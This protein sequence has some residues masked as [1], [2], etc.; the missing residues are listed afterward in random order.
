MKTCKNA[1]ER[2]RERERSAYEQCGLQ[3]FMLNPEN[4]TVHR[5]LDLWWLSSTLAGSWVS[6]CGMLRWLRSS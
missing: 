4:G 5:L 2:E 1:R 3:R 6:G